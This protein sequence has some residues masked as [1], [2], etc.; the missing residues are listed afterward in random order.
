V[1]LLAAVR[2]RVTAFSSAQWRPV[3]G[4]AAVLPMTGDLLALRRVPARYF[5]VFMSVHPMLAAVTGLVLHQSLRPAD[6][7]AIRRDRG[8]QRGQRRPTRSASASGR[9]TP[10]RRPVRQR[11]LMMV[12]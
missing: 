7:L 10:P 5:G 8:G 6:W 3:L 11:V 12:N 2:P 4:L 9:R 1:L